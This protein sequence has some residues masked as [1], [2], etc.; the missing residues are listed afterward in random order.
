M[1]SKRRSHNRLDF[2]VSKGVVQTMKIAVVLAAVDTGN[3][4]TSFKH[5]L[6]K[7][8]DKQTT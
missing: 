7:N 1:I 8:L 4:I 5:L 6:G 3:R 2:K